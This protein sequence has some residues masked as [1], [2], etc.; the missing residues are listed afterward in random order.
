[1][2]WLVQDQARLAFVPNNRDAT[3]KTDNGKPMP[4]ELLLHYNYGAAAVKLWGQATE[5]LLD[6]AKP[7]RPPV[8]VAVL[9]APPKKVS[10]RTIV[11]RKLAAAWAA[12]TNAIGS[13]SQQPVES[14]DQEGTWDEDDVMLFFWGNSR[15]AQE[16]HLK[17]VDENT[18]R[19][20]QW[21]TNLPHPFT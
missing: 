10:N 1:M 15:A 18:E 9:M 5:V 11:C 6:Y 3:F 20:E 14:E 21:R 12:L 17:K 19:M 13:G 2:Q 16:R 4:S 8:P 7:P